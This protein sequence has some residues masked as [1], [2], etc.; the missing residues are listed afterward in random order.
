MKA[1]TI[2][3]IVALTINFLFLM[4]L[5]K[6]Y[7]QQGVSV[8]TTGNAADNSSMLDISSTSKGL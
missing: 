1:K 4:T 8:N 5:D 2:F 6:S 3:N 7:A